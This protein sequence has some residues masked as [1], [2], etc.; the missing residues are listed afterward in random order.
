MANPEN[1]DPIGRV[2]TNTSPGPEGAHPRGEDMSLRCSDVHPECSYEAKG[3]N[4]QELRSQ[5]EQHAREHHNVRE[6]G[7]DTWTKLRRLI[8]RRDAA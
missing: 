4:E 1:R 5:I 8:R 2:P 6:L 7:E 3:K